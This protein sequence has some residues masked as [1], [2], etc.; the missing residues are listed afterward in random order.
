MNFFFD[1]DGTLWDSQERLYSLFCDLAPENSLSQEEY[2]RLKRRKISNE[3]ILEEM[4]HYDKDQV[5][6]FTSSW[7]DRIESPLY[8]KKDRLFPFTR[9]VLSFLHD[10]GHDVYYVT[11]RQSEERALEEIAEKDIARFCVSC[12]VG[13]GA[14]T[15]DQLVRDAGIC[16]V[17]E[18]F[19]IGD[20]GI[21]VMAGKALGMRTIA[22]LSGFR[23]RTVLEDYAPD[24][25][26]NDI[27]DI[28]LMLT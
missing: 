18:D 22:V 7:L 17:R 20:T 2:W 16:I 27:S 4:F 25:I 13:E 26:F 11:L 19:F 28:K 23:E 5:T 14:S 8:L 15:K 1:L 9:E 21:D 24:F 10:K 3:E 12:L 6:A